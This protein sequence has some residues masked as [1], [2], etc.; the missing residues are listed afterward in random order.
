[1]KKRNLILSSILAGSIFTMGAVGAA[2]ACGGPGGHTGGKHRGDKMEH[3][4]KK[5]DLSDEQRQAIES[6]KNEKRDQVE[7]KRDQM[8]DI[9]KALRA[10]A[11][12]AT[13]DANKVRELANEKSQVMADLTVMRFET[14][15]RI[16]KELTAE[17]LE[18]MDKMKERRSKRDDS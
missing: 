9:K 11:S 3:V 13:Y 5:L 14:M 8:S 18:K 2:Q 16:R 1:M 15:N 4:M 7:A 10:Q 6:I 17:Q 12:T